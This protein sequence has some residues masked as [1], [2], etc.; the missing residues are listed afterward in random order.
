MSQYKPSVKPNG[1]SF[2][3]IP[4]KIFCKTIGLSPL[5]IVNAIVVPPYK[6]VREPTTK[7]PKMEA[8]RVN[9]FALRVIASIALVPKL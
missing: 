3:K 8:A 1:I 2:G 7:I 5:G 4:S 6:E 9:S